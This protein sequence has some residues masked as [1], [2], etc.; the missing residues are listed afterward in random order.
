V[1]GRPGVGFVQS[2]VEGAAER[3]HNT[4][5]KCHAVGIT[6]SPALLALASSGRSSSSGSAGRRGKGIGQGHVTRTRNIGYI[7]VLACGGGLA[8][9]SPRPLK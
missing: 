2:F 1:D 6:L 5:L 7:L 3:V 8:S 4:D 9:Q